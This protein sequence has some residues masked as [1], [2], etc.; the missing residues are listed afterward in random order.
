MRSIRL[1][2]VI[3]ALGTP[4]AAQDTHLNLF[5]YEKS[6]AALGSPTVIGEPDYYSAVAEPSL[7]SEAQ[8]ATHVP[9]RRGLDAQGLREGM[10]GHGFNIFLTP[11]FRLR[12]R[13]IH[14]GPVSS[15]SFMPKFTFQWIKSMGGDGVRLRTGRRT[16][17]AAHAVVGH[18]SNGGSTCEFVDEDPDDPIEPCRFP[19]ASTPFREPENRE[20]WVEGGNFSTNYVELG[21]FTRF[22]RLVEV[23]TDGSHWG[24]ALDVGVSLVHHHSLGLPL[25]GGAQPD[26]ARIYGVNRARLD[27]AGHV[28]EWIPGMAIRGWVRFD[29]IHSRSHQFVGARDYVLESELMVQ[30]LRSLHRNAKAPP[31]LNLV[32]HWLGIGVR[33]SRGQDYYNTQFVRDISSFQLVFAVEAWS[34]SAEEVR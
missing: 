15:I 2:A 27:L 20:Y 22:G 5:L 30:G 7:I 29:A 19:T 23:K 3:T 17:F 1:F 34:P 11:Q 32:P 24:W 10:G 28:N 13:N 26:F 8:Y 31:V 4:L 21:A 14:S 16:G 25:P 18:H 6:Y 33:Y 9:L 12:A